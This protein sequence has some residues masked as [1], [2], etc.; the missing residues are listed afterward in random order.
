MTR[1]RPRR[2]GE[3]CGGYA[4]RRDRSLTRRPD[5]GTPRNQRQVSGAG[6]TSRGAAQRRTRQ[7]RPPAREDRKPP[8][9]DIESRTGPA[10]GLYDHPVVVLDSWPLLRRYAGE[11][12]ATTAV[13]DLLTDPSRTAVMSR[14]NF[15]EAM[16]SLLSLYGIKVAHQQKQ[17]L[18]NFIDVRPS[19]EAVWLCAARIKVGW[20]GAW[21]DVVA[22]ATA[23]D[24]DAPLW[25]GDVELLLDDAP[26][27][28]VDLRDPAWV[29]QH[30]R[31]KK[32]IGRRPAEENPLVDMSDAE[33]AA[34]VT[35]PLRVRTLKPAQRDD[36]LDLIL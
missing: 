2:H 10:L 21:G 12:P 15:A 18:R 3:P 13:N 19:S 17:L 24:L 33:L 31:S 7:R 36:D 35:E 8:A 27:R 30:P 32:L 23:I 4:S 1:P 26:W 28:A 6:G 25:T 5:R 29:A 22:A 14:F 16:S 34:F 11:E 9:R 20:Y